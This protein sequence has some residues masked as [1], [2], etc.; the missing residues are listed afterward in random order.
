MADDLLEPLWTMDKVSVLNDIDKLQRK[1]TS[2]QGKYY[3][4]QNSD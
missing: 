2:Y 3:S 4:K 1:R